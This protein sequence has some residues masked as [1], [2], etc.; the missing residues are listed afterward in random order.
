MLRHVHEGEGGGDSA[1]VALAQ[2]VDHLAVI[3]A[4]KSLESAEMITAEV[5]PAHSDTLPCLSSL[6]SLLKAP[7]DNRQPAIALQLTCW[8][9][10]N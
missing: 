10:Q 5:P 3:G 4:V 1:E 7:R 8:R 2:Q 6:V 9:R